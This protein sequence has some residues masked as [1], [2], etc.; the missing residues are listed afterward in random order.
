M[1][2]PAE[3]DRLAHDYY[4]SDGIADHHIEN[5]LQRASAPRILA[6]LPPRGRVL[7]MG[8]GDGLLTEALVASGFDVDLVEGSPVLCAA[9]ERR[10][11]MRLRVHQAMF[12]DFR[13]P[14]AYDSVLAL[15]VLEHV[16]APVV[17]LRHIASWLRPGGSLIVVVPNR[18]SIHRR[19]ALRMGLIS[20]LDDLSPRDHL[21]GHLRVYDMAMLEAELAA[22]GL[23]VEHRFG[24]FLKAVP[25][26]MM[27]DYPDA[28]LAAL[29]AV[30]E[31]LPP[32][33]LANIGLRA[34]K[35]G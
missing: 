29:D 3:L 23:I 17:A 25:N 28:L 32:E 24:S 20:A 27:L 11:G 16:A 35:P 31:A 15:H 7:E 34:R 14:A 22:A 19:V 10:H 18:C 26:G 30:S 13:P 2:S 6:Q 33:A 5:E 8:H 12:E 4:L 9:A 21:V 1:V